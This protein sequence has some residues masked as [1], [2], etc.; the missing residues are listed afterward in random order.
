M[1]IIGPRLRG[2]CKQKPHLAKTLASLLEE[3]L[4]KLPPDVDLHFL[5]TR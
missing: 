2:L 3:Y 4:D 1:E 5:P